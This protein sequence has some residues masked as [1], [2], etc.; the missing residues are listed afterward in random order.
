MINGCYW[1]GAV[2][3][4]T[5][6][7]RYG[8]AEPVLETRRAEARLIARGE[9]C[10]VHLYAQVDCATVRGDLPWIPVCAQELP[11]E[12]VHAYRFGTGQ[13]DRAVHRFPD[14]D[15]GQRGGGVIRHDG[16]HK[17]GWQ[18]NRL[19]GGGR[20]DDGAHELEELRCADDCIGNRGSLDQGF[21]D[22]LRAEV[23]AR[24]KAIGADN[25]QR[26]MMSH[27]GGRFCGKEVVP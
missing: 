15:F 21:L 2:C 7:L 12:F 11:G 9:A 6:P 16:L 8:A 10:I 17:G 14:C 26:N 20:L 1:S 23:T 24:E 27:A 19:T 3:G 22:H 4:V 25:R 5:L 18:P 13:L